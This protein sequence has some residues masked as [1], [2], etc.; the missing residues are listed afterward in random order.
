[1]YIYKS[2]RFES[3]HVCIIL[4][5]ITSALYPFFSP[6]L[7]LPLSVDEKKHL[8]IHRSYPSKSIGWKT[9]RS[10]VMRQWCFA[11]FE[12]SIAC[13][14]S[15]LRSVGT[16]EVWV[17][18]DGWGGWLGSKLYSLWAIQIMSTRLAIHANPCYF[19]FF[20]STKTNERR[21]SS[22]YFATWLQTCTGACLPGHLWPDIC[23][24]VF[25]TFWDL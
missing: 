12:P 8:K 9:W 3:I 4:H 7:T 1:M 11:M 15:F 18:A 17:P 19:L 23:K 14:T 21:G 22:F 10:H 2:Y 13:S 24:H 5:Q 6:V 25:P 20:G 16:K